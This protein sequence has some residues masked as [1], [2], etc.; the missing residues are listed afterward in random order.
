MNNPG[1]TTRNEPRPNR[2]DDEFN[3]ERLAITGRRRLELGISAWVGMGIL[4]LWLFVAFFGPA[5]SPYDQG[6]MISYDSFS[7]MGETG[8]LGGDFIGRDVFSRLLFGARMTMG[9]AFIATVLAFLGGIIFGFTAAAAGEWVDQ[10]LSRIND[11]IMAFPSIMLALIVIASLGTSISVLILTVCLIEITP[12]FRLARALR[13]EIFPNT[14]APLAAEFG[15]RYTYSILFISALSFLG[16]GV[17]PPQADWGAMV[18][19]NLMGL[20]YGSLAPLI[21]AAAIGSLT[22]SINLIV[23]AFLALSNRD[24]SEEMI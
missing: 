10:V 11:A 21:P 17:Q 7:P 20:T 4:L 5:L 6:E 13:R 3:T 9:L 8:L 2:A 15:L 12:V 23:D 1:V 19:E 16:L 22:I 14:L 18:R 24:I